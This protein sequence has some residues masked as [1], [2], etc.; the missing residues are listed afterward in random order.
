VPLTETL[1]IRKAIEARDVDAAVEC[2]ASDAV[3]Y[4][5]F[6]AQVKFRGRDQI[7]LITSVLLEVA[8]DF[9]YTSELRDGNLAVLCASAR[10]GGIDIDFVDHLRLDTDGLIEEFI[11]FT[12][13]LPATAAALR[14]FGAAL[15]R[16]K[17]AARGAVISLLA[18]PLAFMTRSGDKFGVAL[19]RPSIE[20]A[21]T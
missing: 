10:V 7:R 12:R 14:V 8:Q 16:R 3:L 18:A 17:S 15:G 5:P 13:P 6:T 20:A 4:S 11:V 2:F 9:R 1:A 21:A 19:L